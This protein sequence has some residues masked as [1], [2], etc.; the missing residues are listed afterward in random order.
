[1][2]QQQIDQL[3]EQAKPLDIPEYL[4]NGW[5]L[6]WRSPG[7]PIAYTALVLIGSAILHSIPLVGSI[8]AAL[9]YGPLMG[10]FYLA[11]LQQLEGRDISFSDFLQGFNL[12]MPLMLVG[13]FTSL[14]TF[15]GFLLLIL[16]GVY[17]AVAYMFAVPL[18]A[19]RKWDFWPAMEGSR[20]F[21]T[22]DWPTYFGLG[23]ILFIANAIGAMLFGL[24]LL[25]SLPFTVAV[26][27]QAY[28]H[29]LGRGDSETG[30]AVEPSL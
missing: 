2:D 27:A 23:V 1:M 22:K 8:A 10:G 24:G 18:A 28:R 14:F 6:F 3:H 13:L 26:I 11:Y 29:Q 25:I 21:I 12:F 20:R 30:T 16:P 4:S 9:L 15:I 17:L 19:D 5:K 7:L